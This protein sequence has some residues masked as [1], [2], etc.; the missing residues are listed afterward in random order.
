MNPNLLSVMMVLLVVL[1]KKP[2]V[3]GQRLAFVPS[4]VVLP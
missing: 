2:E 4:I 3:A 1:R